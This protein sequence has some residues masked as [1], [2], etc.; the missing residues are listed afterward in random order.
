MSSVA[1]IRVGAVVAERWYISIGVVRPK[2]EMDG[3][4]PF[5]KLGP[6]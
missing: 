6:D 3:V 2:V 4:S 5:S 1:T